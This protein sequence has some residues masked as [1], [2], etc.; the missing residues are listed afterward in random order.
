MAKLKTNSGAKK[1]FALTGT[2][3]IPQSGAARKE[4]NLA[5]SF[6]DYFSNFFNKDAKSRNISNRELLYV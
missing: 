3:K 1:R 4:L 2:G 6:N 5:L